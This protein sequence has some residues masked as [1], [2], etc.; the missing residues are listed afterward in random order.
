MKVVTVQEMQALE[1]ASAR[2]GVTVDA[3]MEKAGLAVAGEAMRS[4][5]SPRGARVLVL[6][7]PGNN[8]GDGLVAARH[9]H[10][11]GARVQVYLCAP[12]RSPDPKRELCEERGI[13]IF[14]FDQDPGLGFL[15]RQ[16]AASSLVVDAVLG[17]GKARRLEGTLK[18]ALALVRQ[19]RQERRFVLLAVDLCTGLDAD[20]GAVDPACPGADI[21][22]ALGYPKV[23]H[24]TFPGASVT[25]L[26]KTADIGMPKGLDE[27][28][29]LE[30]ITSE[31]MASLLPERPLEAHKGSFGR[32]LVVAGSRS[33]IGATML[34]CNGAYR[35]GAGVVTLASPRSVDTMV[36][37]HL[38]ETTHLPLPEME[39]GGIAAMA[40]PVVQGALSGYAALVV[41][42]GLGQAAETVRFLEGLLLEGPAVAALPLVVDADGLNILA[43]HPSWWQKLRARAVLTPH[44]GEMAR[45]TGLP[46]SQ[47]QERRLASAREAAQEWGQVVVLKGA[48]TVVAS[49]DGKARLSPFANPG[50]ATA[51]TGDVLAGAVGGL[52]AQ[53]LT[54]F[55]AATCGVYLHAA[56]AEAVG[57]RLGDAGMVAGDLLPELPR[58]IRAIK[59]GNTRLP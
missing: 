17:T 20:T 6:V 37:P 13:P 30:L 28:I 40:L 42:C 11:W 46:A 9:L 38:V 55:D 34:A 18:E 15:Q 4:L 25:G 22:V 27:G 32:L 23:G 51:G 47:L 56:A 50:L 7:G 26:L 21:T 1:V 5:E 10:Q 44:P 16:L 53:G 14:S 12:R 33:Y 35:V 19:A 29:G 58:R 48:F 43:R 36:A 49:P 2:A 59:A 41:G 54:P 24:F 57:R 39:G 31:L 3:L 45:L 8:G 52:L